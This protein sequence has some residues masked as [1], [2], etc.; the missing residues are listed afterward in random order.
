MG[1]GC[2]QSSGNNLSKSVKHCKIVLFFFTSYLDGFIIFLKENLLL[3]WLCLDV[4]FPWGESRERLKYPDF[5]LILSTCLFLM[6]TGIPSPWRDTRQAQTS[7][8]SSLCQLR[9]PPLLTFNF[10]PI[11][12][13]S[14]MALA[15]GGKSMRTFMG[16]NGLQGSSC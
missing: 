6:V 16:R 4:R 14:F 11:L 5:H 2:L 15:V 1:W 10:I 7:S 3:L 8:G 9:E 12:P 13:F